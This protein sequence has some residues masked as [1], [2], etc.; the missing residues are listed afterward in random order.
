MFNN[1]VTI[2]TKEFILSKVSQEQIFIKYL[3]IEPNDRGSFVNPLRSNDESPGCSFYIDSRGYWKFHDIAA[4]YNWDCFNVVEF[5]YN[6]TFKEALIRIAIDFGILEGNISTNYISNKQKVKRQPCRIRIKRRNW[7][8]SDYAFWKSYHIS[9]ERLAFYNVSPVQQAWLVREDNI[10]VPAYY[11]SY[12]DPC[13]SYYFPYFGTYEYKLYFPLRPKNKFLHVNSNILQGYEQ[14]PQGGDNLLYTKSFKDVMC[15]DN[16]SREFSLYSVAPMSET[17]VVGKE[18]FSDLYNRFDN[19]GTLFDF[20][21]AGIRLMKKYKDE[22][23]LHPYMFGMEF[24]SKLFGKEPIKDFSDYL[25]IK[26]IDETKRLIERFITKKEYESK[27]K[28][29]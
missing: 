7:L 15:I 29:F 1:A 21:R 19:Q 28:V 10:L 24:R 2:I 25:K 17:V 3:Q 26:G 27:E 12:T 20:D 9:E 13:F 14:L 16:F 4:A 22:Y 18:I 6:L 8:K 5:S 11:H 23:K